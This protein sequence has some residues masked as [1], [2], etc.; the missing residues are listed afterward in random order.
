[1]A[2]AREAWLIGMGANVSERASGGGFEVGA[3][4]DEQPEIATPIQARRLAPRL[5]RLKACVNPLR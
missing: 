3:K 5:T 2:L 4:L 1:M